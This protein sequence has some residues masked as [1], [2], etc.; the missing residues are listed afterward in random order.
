[1]G[2]WGMGIS[3]SDDFCEI[4][5]KFMEEYDSGIAVAEITSSILAKYREEFDDNDGIMH[6]VYFAL[7]KAEWMCCEQS[8][9]VLNR[10]KYII[11]NGENIKFLRELEADEKDLTV[12]QKNLESFLE[13]LLSAR[14]KPRK[15]KKTVQASFPFL[16]VGDCF[17]YKFADG[18]RVMVILERF[19]PQTEK[20]Q[21]TVAIFSEIYSANA[22]KSTNFENED[23]G[24]M[25]TVI[26]E[27]FL[28]QS[29]I[30]KIAN[31][32]IVCRGGSRLLGVDVSMYGDK[33]SFR[34]EINR[35]LGITLKEFLWHCRENNEADIRKLEVG[36]C[37]AYKYKGQYKFAV[38]LDHLDIWDKE[39]WLISVL[40][41]VSEIPKINSVSSP[42]SSIA[43]YDKEALPNLAEWEMISNIDVPTNMHKKLFGNVRFIIR[44]KL[45]F[46]TDQ[47]SYGIGNK[48]FSS[49]APLIECCKENPPS[50]F[51]E[52]KIGGCYAY[53]YDDGY[54][55]AVI[56]NRFKLNDIEYLLVAVLKKGDLSEEA[57][58]MS[59]EVSHMGIY[60][61]DTLPNIS[62]W[63]L[64]KILTLPNNIKDYVSRYSTVTSE[65]VIKFFEERP[66]YSGAATL[67]TIL[68]TYFGNGQK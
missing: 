8:E 57:D 1:M 29:L 13:K 40:A 51:A 60:S 15:R 68:E 50:S 9:C 19:K 32:D 2:Y 25:F 36:G 12:R 10:V 38:V 17:A 16:D 54:K 5:D 56:L 37:Y 26:A 7:A 34:N 21:V 39:C 20:E 52:L 67:R 23:L 43:P 35:P 6:D 49:L 22:L 61:Y 59:C 30:K 53:K 64:K 33:K 62:G 46:L 45:D 4:Y 41:C 18:Y 31:I 65:R 11:E 28:G 24:T 58:Y 55:F 63:E 3:Q 14:E 44:G 27:D 66:Y 48:V 47:S 42:I